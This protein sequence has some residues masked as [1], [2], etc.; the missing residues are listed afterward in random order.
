[1][2]DPKRVDIE[3]RGVQVVLLDEPHD[4]Q[5][6]VSLGGYDVPESAECFC[7]SGGDTRA[8]AITE[9]V[10]LFREAAD[11]LEAQKGEA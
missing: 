2:G 8:E 10:R 1:M 4:A 7:W 9:A 11:R 5:V 6:W 3:L